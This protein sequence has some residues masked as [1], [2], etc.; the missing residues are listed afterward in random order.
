MINNLPES[1]K[2]LVEGR[3]GLAR[4]TLSVEEIKTDIQ[5]YYDLYVRD[6]VKTNNKN[7]SEQAF[8]TKGKFKGD[9]HKCGKYG[10]KARAIVPTRRSSLLNRKKRGKR[11]S[12]SNANEWDT[13][14]VSALVTV[15]LKIINAKRTTRVPPVNKNHHEHRIQGIVR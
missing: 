15:H 12:V 11:S 10:H 6:D 1:Y 7:K 13:T 4:N 3:F 2:S 14:Q 8:Y 5:D 9:C